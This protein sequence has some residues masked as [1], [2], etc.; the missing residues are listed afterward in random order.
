MTKSTGEVRLLDEKKLEHFRKKVDGFREELL[1]TAGSLKADAD[2]LTE[3]KNEQLYATLQEAFVIGTELMQPENEALLAKLLDAYDIKQRKGANPWTAVVNLLFV[4]RRKD[5]KAQWIVEVDMSAKK[6][7]P[8]FYYME[9]KPDEFPPEE[10]ADK[11]KEFSYA[12]EKKLKGLEAAG[13]Q[14]RGGR[15]PDEQEQLDQVNLLL[16]SAVPL[17]AIDRDEL[18]SRAMQDGEFILLW[19]RLIG[20]QVVVYGEMDASKGNHGRVAA[21]LYQAAKEAF[22]WT[23]KRVE[24]GKENGK[25][26]MPPRRLTPETR[27]KL[28][29]NERKRF[30]ER[31]NRK[32]A[33]RAIKGGKHHP[34]N[35][36]KKLAGSDQTEP[37]KPA[38]VSKQPRR[39]MTKHVD[40]TQ[41]R[42]LA[43]RLAND[44]RRTGKKKESANAAA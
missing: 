36:D 41:F 6:Y 26:V 28:L 37:V 1:N 35:G 5:R 31:R 32:L 38:R 22:A 4:K 40:P 24:D 9:Q 39:T 13:R 27:E 18:T 15:E 3:R 21:Y 44:P 2:E 8:M 23:K 30:S 10:V 42:R 17:G 25:G 14:L 7:A 20:R 12:K 11:I 34:Q 43:E 33:E 29:E 19:G 16:Q